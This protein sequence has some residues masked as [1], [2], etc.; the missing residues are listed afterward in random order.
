MVYINGCKGWI[1]KN[2]KKGPAP[3]GSHPRCIIGGATLYIWDFKEMSKSLFYFFFYQLSLLIQ[4]LTATPLPS[5]MQVFGSCFF[6][7]VL[8]ESF[9]I[10]L[11]LKNFFKWY[12]DE[13]K[14][15]RWL[16]V[17][18]FNNFIFYFFKKSFSFH[19]FTERSPNI[20]LKS[21]IFHFVLNIYRVSFSIA[22]NDKKKKKKN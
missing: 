13:D 15:Y 6:F 7:F 18:I 19:V 9:V 4:L 22:T 5:I 2:N 17:F 3:F 14:W 12:D 21:L 8:P 11:F 1:N 10:F 16:N 20:T